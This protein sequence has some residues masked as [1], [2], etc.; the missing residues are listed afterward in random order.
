VPADKAK[1]AEIAQQQAAAAVAAKQA[2]EKQ[3]AD[4]AAK[5]LAAQQAA[6]Q[7]TAQEAQA[8]ALAKAQQDSA[9]RAAAAEQAAKDAQAAAEKAQQALAA[10]A[11]VAAPTLS[12]EQIAQQNN[13]IHT[14]VQA[15]IDSQKLGTAAYDLDRLTSGMDKDRAASITTPFQAALGT[16]EQQRDAAIT[17][18]QAG[19]PAA[20][21]DQLKTYDQQNPNDPKIEMAMANV[22]TRMPPEHAA[23]RAQMKQFK[24]MSA[25]DTNVVADPDFQALQTK[26]ANELKQ[27]D[28]MSEQLDSLKGSEDRGSVSRLEAER[29]DA[30]KK[31][32]G[33]QALS[34]TL[35]P[36]GGAAAAGASISDKQREINSLT[37]RIND[38]QNHPA[39]SQADIDDAQQKYDA[40]VAAVPW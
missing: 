37:E 4:E 12:P 32:A 22:E 36:F 11:A 28:A 29:D 38:I 10:Q 6:Q 24:T 31:L 9:A 33:Y 35:G 5:E 25:R 21:L 18:S 34:Q 15:L 27:L 23:L 17:A 1:E 14:Q 40:F 16:Y 26:F 7:A 2:A 3:K 8:A 13:Q 39:A 20:A 30:E 19:D